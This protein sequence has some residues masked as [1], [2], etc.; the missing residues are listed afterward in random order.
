MLEARARVKNIRSFPEIPQTESEV[1]FLSQ[2]RQDNPP[3][4]FKVYLLL[5]LLLLLLLVVLFTGR[6]RG[7]E[8]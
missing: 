8:S 1:V 7:D 6:G 4:E 2:D 5:L 3:D